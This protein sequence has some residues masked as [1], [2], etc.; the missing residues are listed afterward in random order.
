MQKK[1]GEWKPTT[2]KFVKAKNETTPYSPATRRIHN[3][4]ADKNF[5]NYTEKSRA[6]HCI[7]TRHDILRQNTYLLLDDLPFLETI[8]MDTT[9]YDT[10]LLVLLEMIRVVVQQVVLVRR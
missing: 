8:P 5:K 6:Q 1:G 4:A 7:T 9:G 10:P 2:N 3:T